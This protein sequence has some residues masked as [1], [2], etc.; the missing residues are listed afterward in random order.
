MSSL[1][2][3]TAAQWSAFNNWSV[4][5]LDRNGIPPLII[6]GFWASHG[7]VRK[8][9]VVIDSGSSYIFLRL[10]GLHGKRQR[11]DLPVVGGERIEQPESRKVKFWISALHSSEKFDIAVHEVEK[12]TLSVPALDRQW[13]GSFPHLSALALISHPKLGRRSYSWSPIQSPVCRGRDSS[14]TAMQACSEKNQIGTVGYRFWQRTS[15]RSTLWNPSTSKGSM[16]SRLSEFKQRTSPVCLN[17]ACSRDEKTAMKPMESS[18]NRFENRYTISL[19]W[20]RDKA[21]LPNNYPLAERRLFSMESS[22]LKDKSNAKMYDKVITEYRKKNGC[23]WALSEREVQAIA[24]LV[25]CLPHNGIYRPEKKETYSTEKG[26][27]SSVPVPRCFLQLTPTQR[28]MPHWKSAWGPTS[29][30]F[31][32]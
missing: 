32:S 30:F 8:G 29:L 19:P 6:A 28:S 15:V 13:L 27:W 17:I 26:I 11:I 14:R 31:K 10:L 4:S 9:N 2:S 24:R 18:P 21:L 23:A 7:R 16:N 25:Y 5:I 22:L 12:T 20:K 1:L 3:F